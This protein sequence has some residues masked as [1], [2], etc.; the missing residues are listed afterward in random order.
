MHLSIIHQRVPNLCLTSRNRLLIVCIQY[1]QRSPNDFMPCVN[2]YMRVKR[3]SNVC[4]TC[5]WR[6]SNVLNE[7]VAIAQRSSTVL[8]ACVYRTSHPCGVPMT[9]KKAPSPAFSLLGI[10]SSMLTSTATL[11]LKCMCCTQ[12]CH[13]PCVFGAGTLHVSITIISSPSKI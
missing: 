2:A 9:V 3:A 13:T 10:K 8:Q 4:P 1:W 6:V 11:I 7:C 12:L 5:I